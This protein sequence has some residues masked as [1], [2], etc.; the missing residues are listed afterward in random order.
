MCGGDD[1]DGDL[2]KSGFLSHFCIHSRYLCRFCSG[3][4]DT[5]Q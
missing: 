5:W 4:A 1:G 2:A 3:K